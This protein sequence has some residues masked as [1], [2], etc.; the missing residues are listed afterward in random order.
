MSI[1]FSNRTG[2]EILDLMGRRYG[3]RPSS[4]LPKPFSD[5]YDALAF[6]YNVMLLGMAAEVKARDE[7]ESKIN[8]NQNFTTSRREAYSLARRARAAE[9]ELLAERE[10]MN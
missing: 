6:D 9:A 10:A 1:F 4:L 5:A 3:Q 2:P 7:A 8:P